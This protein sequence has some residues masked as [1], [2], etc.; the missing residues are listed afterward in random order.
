[1]IGIII[2]VIIY[3]LGVI[4]AW[5]VFIDGSLE[6]FGKVTV[7]DLFIGFFIN[8]GSWITVAIWYAIVEG[9]KVVIEKKK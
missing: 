8:L 2:G 5:Y 6:H 7:S 3:V 1:M 4:A 9:D